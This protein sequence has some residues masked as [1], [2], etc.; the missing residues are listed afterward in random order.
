[1]E[2]DRIT[3]MLSIDGRVGRHNFQIVGHRNNSRSRNN[4]CWLSRQIFTD[5]RFFVLLFPKIVQYTLINHRPI[6]F[7]VAIKSDIFKEN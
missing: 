5:V 1:M 4:F 6:D 2:A 3:F 7:A